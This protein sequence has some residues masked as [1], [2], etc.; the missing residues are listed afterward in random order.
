METTGLSNEQVIDHVDAQANDKDHQAR[1]KLSLICYGFIASQQG[2]HLVF[3]PAAII[4]AASNGCKK[5]W[6]IPYGCSI[7]VL[8]L[9]IYLLL[10]LR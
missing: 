5:Q 6:T 1:A 2:L 3:A 8:L 7:V 9:T 10:L 4:P